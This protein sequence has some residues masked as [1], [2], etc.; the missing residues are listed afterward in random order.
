MNVKIR[1]RHRGGDD[2]EPYQQLEQPGDSRD[3]RKIL[4]CSPNFYLLLIHDM[5]NDSER[6]EN[7][8]LEFEGGIGDVL[9]GR[10]GEKRESSENGDSESGPIPGKQGIRELRRRPAFTAKPQQA[11]VE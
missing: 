7:G 9:R 6:N 5:K 1:D 4:R 11:K 10:A 8:E 3:G 2:T